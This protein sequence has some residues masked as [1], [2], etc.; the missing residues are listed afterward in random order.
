MEQKFFK[1]LFFVV[2][3]NL[4]LNIVGPFLDKENVAKFYR[5]ESKYATLSFVGHINA[6][7]LVHFV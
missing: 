4:F 5:Y 3:K 6:F 1:L 7:E 2:K